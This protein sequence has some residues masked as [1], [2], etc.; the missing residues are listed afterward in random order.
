MI[1]DERFIEIGKDIGF[2]PKYQYQLMQLITQIQPEVLKYA[3]KA[4]LPVDHQ[5]LLT[6]R[7]L[8]HHPIIQKE[9]IQEITNDLPRKN[10][11]GRVKRWLKT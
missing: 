9:L 1:P 11:S 6:T 4:K 5:M 2:A 8:R 10:V 3:E 7:L